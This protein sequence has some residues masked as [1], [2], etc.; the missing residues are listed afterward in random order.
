[1]EIKYDPVA[2]AG[3]LKIKK[4]KVS[5]TIKIKENLI[6]D[7]DKKGEVLGM[8]LLDFSIP[9]KS[10]KSITKLPVMVK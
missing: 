1:M 9:L 8:E 10:K 5:K 7:L 3:Y 4:G 2:K 6:I